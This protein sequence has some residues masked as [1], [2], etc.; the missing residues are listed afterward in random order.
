MHSACVIV[1]SQ[2]LLRCPAIVLGANAFVI[3]RPFGVPDIFLADGAAASAIDPGTR[4]CSA[5]SATGSTEQRGRGHSLRSL[6]PPQAAL[7]SL[8][9]SV[10]YCVKKVLDN[11]RFS[12]PSAIMMRNNNHRLAHAMR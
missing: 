4:L 5:L 3:C 8:P 1:T 7:P 11:N 6:F 9:R 2:V 12:L 10:R